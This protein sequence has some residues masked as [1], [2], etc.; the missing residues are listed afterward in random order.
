[1]RLIVASVVAVSMVVSGAAGVP[2]ARAQDG[3]AVLE[4]G[5]KARN[6]VTSLGGF[7]G[8]ANV[9]VILTGQVVEIE[10]GG[11]TGRQ[12]HMVASYIYV[13]EGTLT[14][15]SEGGPVG[16]AG[17]QYHAEGQSY[18]DAPAVWHNHR[19]TGNKPVKYL[20]LLIS[21]PGGATTQ[22]AG[23]DD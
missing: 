22:K 17:V 8:A 4:K 10:P 7:R 20:L 9:P 13:L 12:R 21:T 5:V 1:M 14:T 2:G 19:N 16:V 3:K 6:L 11:Q 15:N 23:A 18:M